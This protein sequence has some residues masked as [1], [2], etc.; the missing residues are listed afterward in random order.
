MYK[1]PALAHGRGGIAD[2]LADVHLVRD[3]QQGEPNLLAE[4]ADEV[5]NLAGALRIQGGGC[6]VTEQHRGLEA[7]GTARH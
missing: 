3:E 6:L 5:E 2:A 7:P 1:D 4:L